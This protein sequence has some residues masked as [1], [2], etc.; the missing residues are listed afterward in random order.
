MRFTNDRLLRQLFHSQLT[1]KFNFLTMRG[2][3]VQSGKQ[4]AQLGLIK[5]KSVPTT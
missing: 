1:W 2:K 4:S 5:H 3:S